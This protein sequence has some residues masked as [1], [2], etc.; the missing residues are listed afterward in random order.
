M[1]LGEAS[2]LLAHLL[3]V[4]HHVVKV[5]VRED[6]VVWNAVVRGGRLE[7]MQVREAAAVGSA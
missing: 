4:A 6:A 1:T 7:V 5:K 3:L 2:V